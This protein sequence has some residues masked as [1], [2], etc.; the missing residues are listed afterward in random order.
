MDL[1]FGSSLE[2]SG[3]GSDWIWK[4]SSLETTGFGSEEV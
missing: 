4:R 2:V 3:F 1:E